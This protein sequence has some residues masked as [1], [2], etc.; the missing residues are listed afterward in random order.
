MFILYQMPAY[1]GANAIRME[2][3]RLFGSVE[4]NGVILL[5]LTSFDPTVS[6]GQ[7]TSSLH[8][9]V[10]GDLSD[11]A[12]VDQQKAS[13]WHTIRT[14][15]SH[16]QICACAGKLKVGPVF[17]HCDESGR[18]LRTSSSHIGCIK[19]RTPSVPLSDEFHSKYHFNSP[20]SDIVHMSADNICGLSRQTLHLA[21]PNF[22]TKQN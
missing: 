4:E 8:E 16:W 14:P 1:S 12:P 15:L 6:I 10:P 19:F 22:Q 18:V 7:C 13:V 17:N 3:S 11:P 5:L 21:Y 2:C 20:S 9:L